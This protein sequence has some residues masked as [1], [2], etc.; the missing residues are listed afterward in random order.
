MPAKAIAQELGIS[1]STVNSYLAEAKATLGARDRKHATSILF[2][3]DRSTPSIST[4]ETERV[5]VQPDPKAPIGSQHDDSYDLDDTS[6]VLRD[7]AAGSF[8]GLSFDGAPLQPRSGRQ[9]V[10]SPLDRL[11]MMIGLLIGV[12]IALGVLVVAARGL[13]VIFWETPL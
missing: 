10:L 9:I 11:A 5:A 2:E 1:V 6:T 8:M 13:S 4:G 3:H 7:T 12:T